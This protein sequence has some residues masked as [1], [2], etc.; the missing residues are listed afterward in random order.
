MKLFGYDIRKNIK[1]GEEMRS[2]YDTYEPIFGGLSYGTY[3]AFQSSKALTISA[4][5]RAVNLLSDAI[6]SLQMKVYDVD[7]KGFKT[8]NLNSSLSSLL[9]VEPNPNMSRFTFFKMI[10]QSMLLRGNA[11]IKIN[12]DSKFNIVNLEFINPDSVTITSMGIGPNSTYFGDKKYII[13]GETGMVN[14][15]DM[16]QIL[17]FP[18][19]G[20]GVN[21]HY[22]MSTISYAF[23]TLEVAYNSETHARNWFKGGANASGFLSTSAN[24][25]Q[26]QESDLVTKFKN[27]SDATTG[28]PNGVVFMGGM[29]DLKLN[30]LGISPKDSQL[31]ETRSFNV[32]DIA[33]F[34]NVNPMLLFDVAN[35]KQNNSEN[36]QLDFLNTTLLPI[37]EKLE[38]EFNRKLILPSQRKNTELR[39][40]LSNMLRADMNSRAD[41]YSKLFGMG[42]VSAND[43]AKELNLPKIEGTNGD[44]HFIS[45]NLQ[46]INNLIVNQT[47]SIDNKLL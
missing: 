5:Y 47:N 14:N 36:A 6:A 2:I 35:T 19:I 43:V 9:S 4:C 21:S 11:F 46:Q 30:T 40:D 16:I 15:S 29:P 28:N 12:R 13:A 22:G 1:Q 44:E 24:L 27:A 45:T 41:Y 3:S 25:T 7:S 23:H 31:L 34:F 42:V 20:P 39:F 8:E 17:N 38:N 37:I 26:K 18:Q 33:R 32:L 10:I